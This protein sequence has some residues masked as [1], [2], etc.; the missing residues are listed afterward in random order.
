MKERLE[1]FL[2]DNELKPGKFAQIMGIQPSNITHIISGRSKPGFDFISNML[3]KF[4]ELNPDWLILGNGE[5]Y[6]E[7]SELIHH[8]GDSESTQVPVC[9]SCEPEALTDEEKIG[10]DNN[11]ADI[12]IV[13][14]KDGRFSKYTQK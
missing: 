11:N 7:S 14:H 8:S 9:E 6:R 4:P 13:L 2:Q 3:T 1:A 5:M 10:T 12:I